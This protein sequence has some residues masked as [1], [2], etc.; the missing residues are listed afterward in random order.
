MAA[1]LRSCP[2]LNLIAIC[3]HIWLYLDDLR[4]CD[5]SDL[6]YRPKPWV[7]KDVA[8]IWVDHTTGQGVTQDGVAVRPRIGDRRKNPNL[9]DL[10]ETAASYGANRIML[11]GKRPEPAPGIRHWL[12]VKTPHWKPGSHWVNNGP[13]TGRFEHETTGFK[14]EV[15]TVDEWFGDGMLTPAQ[16][17]VAWD[18]TAAILKAADERARLMMSP[19]A[20]GTNLWALSLPRNVNPVPVS[21]DIAEELHATS[22][23]H[24][25][26]HLVAGPSRS[27][28]ED[29]RALID[30]AS[31]KK[32]SEF[33]YVDGRFMYAALGRELGIG[34]GVRLNRQ[35][36][37]ELLNEDPYARAR[38]LVRFKVPKDW[39]HVGV[40]GV[41]HRRIEDGWYYP[42]VPGASGETWADAAE[43]HVALQHGWMIDPVEAVVFNKARPLDTFTE[44][45]MRARDRVA[46]SPDLNPALRKAVM[47]ALRAI[48][49]HTVG[50]FASSGRD[51]TRVTT[52]ALEIPAEYR[53]KA[54]RQG[55]LF[56]YRIPSERNARTESFYH[57]EV[58]A[59]VWGR[60]RA[61]VL[62]GPSALGLHTAGALTVD[63][64][65]LIGINGDAIYTTRLPAWSL[66]AG[67]GGGDDGKTGRLRLQGYLHGTFNTPETLAQRD[68]LR[69]RA[70]KAGI[71]EALALQPEAAS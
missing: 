57:P 35:R 62:D 14:I 48:V 27:A 56:I 50:A 71:E 9:T 44:R 34:P 45:M 11:T 18:T 41:R 21:A 33:A 51:Q 12:Y 67:N 46:T 66:P 37:F 36:A 59:Q 3:K 58:A 68:S 8:T 49:L 10:L 65:T 5:V 40:L 6:D 31:M 29:T 19:A 61:R 55:E 60:A 32:I 70:E 38:F 1:G 23:Q 22:G 69:S 2:R 28:H 24:H 63:P 20:T 64:G 7:P 42:N 25:L 17:R 26:E 39:A 53:T 52:N 47:A 13:V 16:A 43:V 15:R 30:P 54:Q 4:R